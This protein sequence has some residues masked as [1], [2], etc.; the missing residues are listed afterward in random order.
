M[1]FETID[2]GPPHCNICRFTFRLE[3]QLTRWKSAILASF[4]SLYFTSPS[5]AAFIGLVS[6]I[7]SGIEL[8]SYNTF[9]ILSFTTVLKNSA[10]WKMFFSANM[11]AD[12]AAALSRIQHLL[13]FEHCDIQKYLQDSFSTNGGV[14]LQENEYK[15]GKVT[16]FSEVS[17][18]GA[19]VGERDPSILLQNVVCSWYRDWKKVTLNNL[20]LSVYKGDLLFITGPVG[21]GKSSLLHAILQEIPLLKGHIS[22]RGKLSWVGQ[23]PWVFSGTIRENILFGEPF[24]PQRYH[25]I[26]RTCN[27]DRDMQRFP[28]ADTTLVGERGIVLSGGQRA[29]VGLARALYSDADIYLLDDP[30]SALD[31]KVGYHIFKTCVIELLCD[32]TRLMTTHNLEI[33]REA[34]NIVAMK[35][36]S[37]LQQADFNTLVKSGFELDTLDKY[38]TV[39]RAMPR[40][41]STSVHEESAMPLDIEYARLENV[42]EDRVIGSVSWMLYLDYIRAGMHSASAVALV[43]SFLVV[44]G[45]LC[46]IIFYILRQ[47]FYRCRHIKYW[48]IS[49]SSYCISDAT[50]NEWFLINRLTPTREKVSSPAYHL[51]SIFSGGS[52]VE[53]V[54]KS[55]VLASD[56]G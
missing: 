24:D 48:V 25:M 15:D 31:S 27:L 22:S 38:N 40:G 53:R 8:T 3:L 33:L 1:E 50:Q 47:D 18:N 37:I 32:K 23:Q 28:D 6:L 30:L 41:R 13:E 19:H 2:R 9:M 5:F 21:C 35:D 44:Q 45:K 10:S 55:R 36:G 7:S 29:R 17:T 42:E 52:A 26:L 56:D 49:S 16:L 34:D 4:Q 12:F 54:A 46:I 51:P 11:L 14:D 43:V 20:C 39:G